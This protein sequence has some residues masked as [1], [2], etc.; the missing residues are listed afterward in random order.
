VPLAQLQ[1]SH[2]LERVLETSDI[3]AES[4][5]KNAQQIDDVVHE[6]VVSCLKSFPGDQR[7]DIE[8][9]CEAS[10]AGAKALPRQPE[11][12]HELFR[13]TSGPGLQV[14]CEAPA[15]DA[16]TSFQEHQENHELSCQTSGA[17][18]DV[19]CETSGSGARAILGEHQESYE[20]V[21]EPSGT[22]STPKGHK[23]HFEIAREMPLTPLANIKSQGP[24]RT[25]FPDPIS[26]IIDLVSEDPREAEKDRRA[27]MRSKCTCVL[28]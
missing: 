16:K 14:A 28:Q 13:Q 27:Q 9:S 1:G 17:G 25:E 18:F 11:E 10:G 12:N 6:N 20:L 24:D 22:G 21:R 15:S 2:H 19:A 3:D 26:T 8:V 5:C 7:Q 23:G 4:P